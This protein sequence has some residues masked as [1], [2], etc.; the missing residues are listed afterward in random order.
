[1]AG[2]GWV[3]EIVIGID[4]GMTCTGVFAL[5][6]NM[7]RCCPAGVLVPLNIVGTYRRRVFD[8]PRLGSA[9]DSSALAWQDV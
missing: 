9:T 7:S 1:M 5:L 8:G 6:A 3:P 4:F 2:D